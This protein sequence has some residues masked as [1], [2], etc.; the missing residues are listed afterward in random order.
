M[1]EDEHIDDIFLKGLEGKSIE[2]PAGYWKD[3][4]SHILNNLSK[5]WWST[6]PVLVM[7]I[8]AVLTIVVIAWYNTNSSTSIQME[9]KQT[10]GT[11]TDTVII[12]RDTYEE[13]R[14]NDNVVNA[15]TLEEVRQN[16]VT[17][18]VE[19]APVIEVDKPKV[20]EH[21]VDSQALP[22]FEDSIIVVPPNSV[23]LNIF[24]SLGSRKIQQPSPKILNEQK[25]PT[26]II[27]QDT[28]IVTDTVKIEKK[29]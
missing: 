3:I 4:S 7:G 20:S 6:L 1:N 26:V 9:P 14:Q 10:D 8:V 18:P 25:V 23:P 29:K 12:D 11:T 16:E 24:D 28:V 15:D 17:I 2:K 21:L 5:P 27:I 22:V 13:P 19:K